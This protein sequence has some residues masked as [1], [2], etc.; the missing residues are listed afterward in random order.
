MAQYKEAPRGAGSY[1]KEL[2]IV[3][4]ER[5]RSLKRRPYGHAGIIQ[6]TEVP[7]GWLDY[8]CPLPGKT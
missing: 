3:K 7:A 8:T 5:R 6:P 2:Q 1:I 4:I